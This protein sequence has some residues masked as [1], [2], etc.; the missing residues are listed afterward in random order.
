MGIYSQGA[1]WGWVDG[2]LLT[3][4]IKSK[5]N[6]GWTN[7]TGFLLTTG[8][9]DQTSS[10][11]WWRRMRHL[12]SYWGWSHIEEWGGSWL[13]GLG[14]VLL[15][16][17]DLQW[18]AHRNLGEGSEAWLKVGQAKNLCQKSHTATLLLSI[19]KTITKSCPGEGRGQSIYFIIDPLARPQFWW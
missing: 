5:G 6:S 15:L 14:S 18:S 9:G 2:K 1:D 19:I 7:L 12:I 11:A 13:N 10:R 17:L 8:Q 16:K 4:N 3:G